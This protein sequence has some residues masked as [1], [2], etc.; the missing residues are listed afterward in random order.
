MGDPRKQRKKYETPRFPW[1]TDIMQDELKLIGQYGLRNKHEL[2]RQETMMSTFRGTARSLIGKTP[3]E[4]TKMEEELL[5]RLKRL[6]ILPEMAVLDDVL[7]MT[8]EDILERRLQTI[9]L[10][11]GLAKTIQQSRQLITHGHVT[12]GGKRVKIPGHIVT[13]H[14]EDQ[15]DYAAQSSLANPSHPLRQTI[16]VTPESQ[17]GREKARGEE[18]GF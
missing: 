8:I 4:R 2:W 10:R 13:K 11:K 17:A 9:V 3:E 12:I 7:D 14:E 18:E 6:G 15:I 16:T 1:R 5:A